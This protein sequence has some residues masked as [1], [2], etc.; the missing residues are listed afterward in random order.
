M[1]PEERKPNSPLED[2]LFKEFYR[3]S[4]FKA[5]HLFETLLPDR[6][7][8]GHAL[9][10]AEEPLRFS[11]S[12]GLA[13]PPSDISSLT[14]G[15]QG[16][17]AKLGVAFMGLIGPSGVLPYWYNELAIARAREKD[18]SLADFLDI[19]H[20]RLISLFYL[21]WKRYRFPENYLPGA[22]DRLS[23]C[24]LSLIGLGTAGLSGRIRQPE[25]SL[26]FY[27]GLLSR[28]VPSGAAV[29][30][31]VAYFSGARAQVDQFIERVIALDPEDQTRVGFANSEL[32]V[33]AVCGGYVKE[34]QTRFRV[35]LGPMGFG[36]FA[37]F[38]PSGS[39][40]SRIFWL[41]RYM[42]GMEYE[43][44]IRLYLKREEVPL[45]T[46]GLGGL[47]SPRLGWTTWLKTPG[48]V[49]PRD[50]HVTFREADLSAAAKV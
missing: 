2:R 28:Q 22:G 38:L 20:H 23:H 1:A 11:V 42:V 30:A 33:S 17:P 49:S 32:G 39:E 43:F 7:A 40:L 14:R 25:E 26:I 12:P 46:V 18:F 21:A 24:L 44:E 8:V 45:C 31:T 35:N 29:E 13:F 19:F 36:Q 10:P 6:K 48:V 4:F 5:V 50:P 15:E 27:S 37:H 41:V 47:A 34:N 3:F 9:N 16:G